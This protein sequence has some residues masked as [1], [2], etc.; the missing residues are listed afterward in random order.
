MESIQAQERRRL[1]ERL[2]EAREYLELSQDEVAKVLGVPRSAVSLIEGGQRRL[3]S[4]ELKRLS[5]LYQR[6]VTYF[7]GAEED[8]G[9]PE[10]VQ[11][12]ARAANK[13][14][15]QDRAELLRFAEFLQS[16]TPDGAL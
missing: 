4:L 7:T 11:H 16:R 13:L 14:S 2:K 6:P 3:D 12:L 9:T 15:E 10:I 5:E 1:G 8:H